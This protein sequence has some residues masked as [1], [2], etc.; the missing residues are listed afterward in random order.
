MH[1]A[2]GVLWSPSGSPLQAVMQ[3]TLV[4]MVHAAGG[5]VR[6]FEHSP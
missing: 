6:H 1:P 4:A 3:T 5:G 2:W